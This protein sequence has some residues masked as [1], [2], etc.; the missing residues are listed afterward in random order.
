MS[1]S[2]Y[3][4]YSPLNAVTAELKRLAEAGD[5]GRAALVATQV[6]AQL[7][8]RDFPAARPED[9]AAIESCLANIAAVTERASPLQEDIGRLLQAFDPKL[10]KT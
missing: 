3:S 9:R 2:P 6:S 5:W 8:A 7:E 1:A 4:P 10:A